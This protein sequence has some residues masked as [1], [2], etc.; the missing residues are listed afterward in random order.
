M[1][2]RAARLPVATERGRE[3]VRREMQ[4]RWPSEKAA[5]SDSLIASQAIEK[6][7][8][9]LANGAIARP[10]KEEVAF[11]RRLRRRR[12]SRVSGGLPRLR[13]FR[14]GFAVFGG[15]SALAP[16]LAFT[17]AA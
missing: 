6:V 16:P 3:G 4:A 2:R 11:L 17:S 15:A 8:F 13:G 1:K 5:E 7:R 10:P 12:R 14:A 9:G